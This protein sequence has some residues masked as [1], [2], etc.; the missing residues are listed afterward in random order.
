VHDDEGLSVGPA[1]D[2]ALSEDA[3]TDLVAVAQEAFARLS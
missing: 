1:P 2:A 3:I